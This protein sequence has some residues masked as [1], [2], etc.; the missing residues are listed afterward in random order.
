M[1]KKFAL[2]SGL[3]FLMLVIACSGGGTVDPNAIA[4][5]SHSSNASSSGVLESENGIDLSSSSLSGIVITDANVQCQNE[6]IMDGSLV[7]S[8]EERIP[9][10]TYRYV[11]TERTTFTIENILLTCDIEID[12]LKVQVSGDTV[13]VKVKYDYTNALRCI[14]KSKIDFSVDNDDAYT[15]ATLLYFDNGLGSLAPE[16]MDIVDVE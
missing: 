3:L 5:N 4:E 7:V 16:I 14:C 10:F 15:H 12:T 11:G 1:F 8:D 13:V 9:P 6:R 2:V